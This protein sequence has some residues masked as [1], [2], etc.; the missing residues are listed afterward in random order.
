MCMADNVRPCYIGTM[1]RDQTSRTR[2][3]SGRM[4]VDL[5]DELRA[6]ATRRGLSMMA[7]IVERC[8]GAT[9][10]PRLGRPKRDSVR[11]ESDST[12]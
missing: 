11:L 12:R 5:Y 1:G 4:P 8:G 3:F 2:D 7:V 6:E 9:R 10:D